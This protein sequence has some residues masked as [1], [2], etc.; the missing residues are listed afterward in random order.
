MQEA[1]L[2]SEFVIW[3]LAISSPGRIE[4]ANGTA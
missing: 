2:A 1:S 3:M 4:H